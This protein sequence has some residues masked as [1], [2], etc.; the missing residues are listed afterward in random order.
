M[1]LGWNLCL[2]N[3]I[4][5]AP[6]CLTLKASQLCQSSPPCR[7]S[8]VPGVAVGAGDAE[9]AGAT[10]LPLTPMSLYGRIW[11]PLNPF[12]EEKTDLSANIC[13]ASQP[14][15]FLPEHASQTDFCPKLPPQGQRLAA[16]FLPSL[17]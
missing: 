6:P 15:G 14:P 8:C 3:A 12:T 1:E 7:H 17:N 13:P 9:E 4:P 16:S 5:D 10:I 11:R 2:A